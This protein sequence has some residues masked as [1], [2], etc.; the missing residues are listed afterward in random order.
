MSISRSPGR[1]WS[2]RLAVVAA[3]ALVLVAPSLV[4]AKWTVE[5]N[6][7]PTRAV[8]GEPVEL[9]AVIEVESHD[10]PGESMP[11]LADVEA[12]QFR[13]RPVG[14]GESIVVPAA[15]DPE[16]DGRY[17]AEVALPDPGEWSVELEFVIDGQRMSHGEFPRQEPYLLTVEALRD[18][19][20]GAA[21]PIAM[22]G[23]GLL[24]GGAIRSSRNAGSTS[25]I[26]T[27]PPSTRTTGIRWST[28]RERAEARNTAAL[29]M[30]SP[31]SIRPRTWRLFA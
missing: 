1:A 16:R 20:A 3:V 4:L 27:T 9:A 14:G 2:L 13:V 6:F 26:A 24:A 5:V 19:E 25:P 21:P 18:S 31:S 12:V 23:A 30:T 11:T 22:L 15:A 8:T 7:E 29:P 17:R 28:V 10:V